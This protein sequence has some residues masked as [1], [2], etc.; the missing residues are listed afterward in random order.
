MSIWKKKNPD[1]YED[2]DEDDDDAAD[3]D[4]P[5]A[6]PPPDPAPAKRCASRHTL[7][8][9][10][11]ITLV[12]HASLLLF[13]CVCVCMCVYVLVS[14]W[15]RAARGKRKKVRL[16]SSS[17]ISQSVRSHVCPVSITQVSEGKSEKK[18]GDISAAPLAPLFLFFPRA[19]ILKR[20]TNNIP[21]CIW[22]PD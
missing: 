18:C 7:N 5:Y 21:L 4:D 11:L 17:S 16:Q 22:L 14:V 10:R 6:P 19:H 13:V 3:L 1:A 8:L 9:S 20:R 2:E 15:T 12:R